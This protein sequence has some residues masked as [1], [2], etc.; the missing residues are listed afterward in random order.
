[1]NQEN[2]QL[3]SPGIWVDADA[4]PV[5]VKEI[6]FRAAMRTE[7]LLT[8]VANQAIS[9]PRSPYIRMMQ[10]P[11]GFDR[12]DQEIVKRVQ[13]DDLVITSDIPLAAE[14]ID[15]QGQVLSPR[16]ERFTR[17]NIGARLGMRDFLESMRNSGV[18]VGGGPAAFSQSD[19]QAFARQ[20]DKWLGQNTNA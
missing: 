3:R 2:Q 20:L 14:V 15:R 9:V 7:T 10:V 12:A 13:A 16:G 4:C 17:E 6:L 11:G 19:K 5:A 1:M 8:L 18:E